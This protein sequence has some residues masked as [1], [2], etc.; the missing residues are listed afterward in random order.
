M[1]RRNRA[2]KEAKKQAIVLDDAK[3]TIP[4][5]LDYPPVPPELSNRHDRQKEDVVLTIL[6]E[7]ISNASNYG[8]TI[9]D[10]CIGNM[11]GEQGAWLFMRHNGK[12]MPSEE[13]RDFACTPSSSKRQGSALNGLGLTFAASVARYPA[14]LIVAS[15]A[16]NGWKAYEG[17]AEFG[18]AGSRWLTQPRDDFIDMLKEKFPDFSKYSVVYAYP[19]GNKITESTLSTKYVTNLIFQCGQYIGKGP[20]A[21][22]FDRNLPKALQI[23]FN[24]TSSQ[25]RTSG[26]TRRGLAPREEYDERYCDRHFVLPVSS[27]DF[28]LEKDNVSVRIEEAVVHVYSYPTDRA[29]KGKQWLASIRKGVNYKFTQDGG[30]S[31][32]VAPLHKAFLRFSCLDVEIFD[33]N[34]GEMVRPFERFSHKAPA[35][36]KDVESWMQSLG[37]NYYNPG[38]KFVVIELDIQKIKKIVHSDE[39]EDTFETFE[40]L[41][42]AGFF[43]RLAD[44]TF[45][46]QMECRNLSIEMC[47]HISHDVL[48]EAREYFS[49][50]FPTPERSFFE[51]DL[52][53]KSKDPVERQRR[54]EVFD[55]ETA[56]KFNRKTNSGSKLR[57]AIFDKYK[58][59]WV[60]RCEM[61]VPSVYQSSATIHNLTPTLEFGEDDQE[62]VA[63]LTAEKT[64]NVQVVGI[65]ISN[66]QRKVDGRWVGFDDA[67]SQYSNADPNC[68]P[69]RIIILTVRGKDI[70]ICSI[71]DLPQRK[72]SKVKKT[73]R[74]PGGSGHGSFQPITTRPEY[75]VGELR[76]KEDF[77]RLNE[78]HPVIHKYFFTV[79]GAILK[80]LDPIYWALNSI[81]LAL[82]EGTNQ[83]GAAPRI[84]EGDDA[85]YRSN[86]LDY[87]L[88]LVLRK[89]L[90]EDKF[91]KDAFAKIDKI[92]EKNMVK[93]VE[94][95]EIVE[96]GEIVEAILTSA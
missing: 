4:P 92:I 42:F 84:P 72:G 13:V 12:G 75:F 21:K 27:F 22:G 69:R 68:R 93:A 48:S 11:P 96:A 54:F 67:G 9:F 61:D 79:D 2:T 7:G 73:K 34:L 35:K 6:E 88:S 32:G 43:G 65:S 8:A 91:I 46:K 83:F 80:L 30:S 64:N 52:G 71:E 81:A 15:N 24:E 47:N 85:E 18:S 3:P 78:D 10:A 63:I 41:E 31:P 26:A 39:D 90:A 50:L 53:G 25:K 77:L 19:L 5:V 49:K 36:W 60:P 86:K 23:I 56:D 82:R 20:T 66:A 28:E 37:L 38:T 74:T 76:D 40:P 17:Y 62:R 95:D 44:F 89:V 70:K 94:A 14:R 87:P 57:V 1:S 58:R 45:I 59:D 29:V 33:P 51:I 16:G 55:F